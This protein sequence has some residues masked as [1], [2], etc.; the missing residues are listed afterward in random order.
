MMGVFPMGPVGRTVMFVGSSL[1]ADLL[2]DEFFVSLTRDPYSGSLNLESLP[3][4]FPIT[5]HH[6]YS[7]YDFPGYKAK[8]GK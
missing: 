2:N 8:E 1:Q 6:L 4:M 5:L 3:A 7:E